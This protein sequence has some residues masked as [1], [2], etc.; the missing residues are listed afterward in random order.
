MP[1]PYGSTRLINKGQRPGLDPGYPSP[2]L[3][4]T[5]PSGGMGK[6]HGEEHGAHAVRVV[7]PSERAGEEFELD[8]AGLEFGGQRH[9]LC[10][11]PGQTLELVH[12]EDDRRLRGGLLELVGQRERLLQ[13]GPDLETGADLLL[14]GLVALRP[15][16]GFEL[17]R[18]FLAGARGAGVPDADRSLGAGRGHD[19]ERRALL[20]RAARVPVG[21]D[22]DL[23][24]LA[25]RGDEDE[26]RGVV[27]RGG[28]PAPGAE[29]LPAAGPAATARPA[30]G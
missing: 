28:L 26:A 19:R 16:Q 12:R 7:D 17:A 9:Q 25:E 27:L 6:P 13:L 1:I 3:V 22:G 30:H 18:Q 8:A 21:G 14:E 11:V 5:D 2:T 4:E 15:M 10:R 20:P 23:Q 29:A 24:F